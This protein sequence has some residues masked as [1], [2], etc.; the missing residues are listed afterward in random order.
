MVSRGERERGRERREGERERGREGERERGREGE[1]ERG[2]EGER[3]RGREGERER[4]R[5]RERETT[6]NKWL[7]GLNSVLVD[8][9]VSVDWVVRYTSCA[10]FSPL[11]I[12]L[13]GP[14]P[15]VLK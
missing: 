7:S 11:S 3:E 13:A 15:R 12:P 2:R 14:S 5:E 6:S 1:R 9:E 8:W 10:S 4:E